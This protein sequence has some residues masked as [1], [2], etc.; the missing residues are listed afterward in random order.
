MSLTS[1]EVVVFRFGGYKLGMA[2]KSRKVSNVFYYLD[3]SDHGF[4]R[5]FPKIALYSGITD[6]L[7]YMY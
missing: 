7:S 4:T 1:D 2:S 5:E 3:I 6:F